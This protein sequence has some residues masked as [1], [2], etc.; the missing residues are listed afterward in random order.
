MKYNFDQPVQRRGTNSAKWDAG[1]L[2]VAM[3]ITPYA[4]EN[5]LPLFT[6]GNTKGSRPQ[7]LRLYHHPPF[8]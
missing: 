8:F 7:P 6:G 5:T 4:D 1:K 3:G 2:L